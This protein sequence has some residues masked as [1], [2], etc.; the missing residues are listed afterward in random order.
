MMDY[1]KIRGMVEELLGLLSED[2]EMPL[3]EEDK[4]VAEAA[5]EE[6]MKK[7]EGDPN[8][9]EM[10]QKALTRAIEAII[11]AREN[12]KAAARNMLKAAKAAVM[13]KGAP[14]G[15]YPDADATEDNI[16][17]KSASINVLKGAGKTP[18]VEAVKAAG[19][20]RMGWAQPDAMKAQNPYIGTLGG[21]LVGQEISEQVLEPLRAKV[22]AFQAGVR[23]TTVNGIGSYTIPKMT[24]APTAYRP[25][26]TLE[27]TESEAKFDTITAFLRPI[28]ARVV[29]PLQLMQ[30]SPTAAEQIIRDEME[31][32]IRL[33]IDKEIF[34][35]EGT[36]TQANPGAEIRGILRVLQ[37]DVTV[38]STNVVTL[39]TNGRVPNYADLVAA[40]TQVA[41]GNVEFNESVKFVM[42]PTLRGTFRSL[43]DTIG[44]PLSYQNFGQRPYESM[45]G[46][47]V[48]TSTQLP[49]NL[50]T[51]S[52]SA[53]SDVFFGRFD[54][55]EYVMGSDIQF[56][57]DEFSLSNKLMVQITAYTF[58]DFIVH[59][60][61]AFYVMRGALR[62]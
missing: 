38:S 14:S 53:T 61:Q 1:S 22:I 19:R 4:A 55:A 12:K 28:A 39:A 13:P 43:T 56:I 2:D 41:N 21:Y 51:G 6:E 7:A 33:Q 15:S 54:Y 60:P 46:Y 52:S 58:S 36:A 11:T 37:Q 26:I 45:L 62:A 23:Q 59:Y 31:R 49:N 30:T 16:A 40:E 17:R 29:I 24:T 35:G 27:V 8:E 5:M 50:T 44:Q 42:N 18:L 32:S 57:V 9:E 25:G 20:A 34:Y 47:E 10:K 3:M 48:L